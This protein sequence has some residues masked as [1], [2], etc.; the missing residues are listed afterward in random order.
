[1]VSGRIEPS[2][3]VFGILLLAFAGATTD[4][5]RGKIYNWLTLP[6]MLLGLAASA[7]AQGW[8]GVSGSMIAIALGLALYGWIFVVGAMGAGDVKFLMALGAWSGQ[9]GGRYTVDTALLGIALGGVM[10]LLSLVIRGKLVLFIRKVWR[11]VF[12]GA[13]AATVGE[14]EVETPSIDR[15][16]TL[17]FGIPI[18]LAAAWT[19]LGDPLVKWG[20]SLW[21]S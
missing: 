21:P 6:G 1:M 17:P 20:M 15:S 4:V 3:L 12:T 8:G 19:A 13:L 11:L 2:F 16:L 18:A 10:A 5:A 14:I 7:W 9:S